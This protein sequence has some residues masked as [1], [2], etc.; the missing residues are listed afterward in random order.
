VKANRTKRVRLY[1]AE[2]DARKMRQTFTDRPVECEERYPFDWPPALQNVG[3]SL[4]VAYASD[5]WR[6]KDRYGKRQVE[7]YKHLA[8]SRNQALAAPG[9]LVDYHE[10]DRPWPVRGPMVSLTD[11]ELEMPT[12]FAMLGLFEEICLKLYTAGSDERP[13]FGRAQ[14]EGVVHCHLRHAYLGGSMMRLGKRKRPFIFVFTKAHGVMFLVTGD[15]L[16]VEKDGIVG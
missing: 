16:D 5:K 15:E 10:R 2:A 8:E 3:D 13:R 1:D 12:H 4:A 6:P 9:L 14:D 7:L 11:G